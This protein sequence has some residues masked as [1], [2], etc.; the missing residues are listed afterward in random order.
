MKRNAVGYNRR[1]VLKGMVAGSTLCM[2]GDF[3]GATAAG[4]A[5]V[6]GRRKLPR[7]NPESV[8]IDPAS[9]LAF[10]DAVEQKVGGLHSLMLLR[11]GKV[12][13]EGWW[14]PYAPK[15]PHMLY[16]LSKSFT[17]TALGLAVSEGKLTVDDRVISF[18]PELL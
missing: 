16:S 11:H 12:A 13:A 18:F 2:L 14:A 7:A 6:G 4:A 1:T 5:E 17:S 9:V 15:H 8:G 3:R 10:V